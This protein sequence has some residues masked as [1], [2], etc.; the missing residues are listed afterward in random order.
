MV[1]RLCGGFRDSSFAMAMSGT[2][3]QGETMNRI[4]RL[5]GEPTNSSAG[6]RAMCSCVIL[7]I[8]GVTLLLPNQGSADKPPPVQ[9]VPGRVPGQVPEEEPK[10][11]FI[12]AAPGKG[13]AAQRPASQSTRETVN[14]LGKGLALYYSFDEDSDGSVYDESGNKLHGR[15]VGAVQYQ[16]SFRG[17]AAKFTSNRTYILCDDLCMD[18]WPRLTASCWM[19]TNRITNHAQ[20]MACGQVVGEQMSGFVM[21][22][23]GTSKAVWGVTTEYQGRSRQGQKVVT[24][25]LLASRVRRV[26]KWVHVAGVF[27][28]TF[29]KFY[30]N[31]KLDCQNEVANL[32][33]IVWNPKSHKLVIGNTANKSRMAW[34]DKYFDGLIDEVKIWKRALSADEIRTTYSFDSDSIPGQQ[35]EE[36]VPISP[37]VTPSLSP[38]D[39][40][41]TERKTSSTA[42][43]PNTPIKQLPD[44]WG[45]SNSDLQM[46]LSVT[47]RDGEFSNLH[48]VRVEIRNNRKQTIRLVSQF[49]GLWPQGKTYESDF[50]RAVE[51]LADS[52]LTLASGSTAFAQ[53]TAQ[54]D[55][56]DAPKRKKSANIKPGDTFV[57]RWTQT[58]DELGTI[59]REH[60][61]YPL[62][63]E[64]RYAVRAHVKVTTDSGDE[65]I[66][67]SNPQY[68][69]VGNRHAAPYRSIAHVRELDGANRSVTLDVGGDDDIRIADTF[70]INRKGSGWWQLTITNT[71]RDRSTAHVKVH[72][73]RQFE[74]LTLLP[75]LPPAGTVVY[76][77]TPRL[78]QIDATKVAWCAQHE[79]LIIG[80]KLNKSRFVRGEPMMF[81]LYAM[82]TGKRELM[83]PAMQQAI[84]TGTWS[85]VFQVS[86][87]EKRFTCRHLVG[88]LPPLE[89]DRLKPDEVR[90]NRVDIRK[91]TLQ[92]EGGFV[93]TLPAGQYVVSV[94]YQTQ[95][96]MANPELFCGWYELEVRENDQ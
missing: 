74:P 9:L 66:L 55:A 26:D 40:D 83:I 54:I 46:R 35:I 18:R 11:P 78:D 32:A 67:A 95:F 10:L 17:N 42:A 51:F 34:S 93:E 57:A 50:R 31:G 62:I 25:S 39:D 94:E 27:D 59:S 47:N 43:E 71:W 37:P 56:D 76:L 91:M 90:S 13:I 20:V 15:T 21:Q 96:G 87:E 7:L 1:T 92:T 58:Y 8:A 30:I 16:P 22:V 69:V 84:E 85:L 75:E 29:V 4:K 52:S 82:N 68:Y 73:E 24:S 86:G 61:F 53:T 23:G 44:V 80:V 60:D 41:T 14:E 81:D 79:D 5:L 36:V 49:E 12:T 33:P 3:R 28:G 38:T 89:W 63:R 65:I 88:D 2:D 48:D 77:H 6:T 45:E 72:R 70:M 64:G 19:K